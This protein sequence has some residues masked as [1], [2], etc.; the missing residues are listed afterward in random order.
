M[1]GMYR[2]AFMA[3][4]YQAND[5]MVVDCW[6]LVD[7]PWPPTRDDLQSAADALARANASAAGRSVGAVIITSLTWV[8]AVREE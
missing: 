1:T 6:G 3:V 7:V 5:D 8:S 4:K 2:R